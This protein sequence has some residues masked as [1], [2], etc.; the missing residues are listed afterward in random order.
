QLES[1]DLNYAPISDYALDH[2]GG[3]R[4]LRELILYGCPN[5]TDVGFAKLQSLKNLQKL[6]V[7][8]TRLTDSQFQVLS[9]KLFEITEI[10]VTADG[11]SDAGLAGLVNMRKL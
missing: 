6:N 8:R 7:G 3:M 10:N 5:L 9:T 11:V 2:I 4:G 1:L